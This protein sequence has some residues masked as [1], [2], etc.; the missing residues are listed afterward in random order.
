MS[1]EKAY[2][3]LMDWFEYEA[4]CPCCLEREVCDEDCTFKTDAPESFEEMEHVR[5]VFAHAKKEL[6]G[7]TK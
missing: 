4:E 1:A 2:E 3:I 5:A 6:E 7:P